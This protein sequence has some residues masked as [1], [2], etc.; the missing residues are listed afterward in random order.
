[1]LYR[2]T[3]DTTPTPYLELRLELL[4]EADAGA[5]VG[6]DVD[7]REAELTGVLRSGQEELILSPE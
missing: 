5:R 2:H 3:N 7:S 1:M 4:D 6:G